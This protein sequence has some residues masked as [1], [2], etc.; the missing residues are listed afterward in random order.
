MPATRSW[1]RRKSSLGLVSVPPAK[2]GIYGVQTPEPNRLTFCPNVTPT[3]FKTEADAEDMY[4]DSAD[5]SSATLFPPSSTP[6][7]PPRRRRAPPGKRR[8][9]GYIPRPPNAFMLFRADFVKQKHVPNSIETNHSSLSKIIGSCWRSLPTEE[10][11]IWEKRAR[12]EKAEHKRKY[13]EYRFRPVHNKN[14]TKSADSP[15]ANKKTKTDS[16]PP[17]LAS[18][19]ALRTE[20]EGF[21]AQS[22]L[23]GLKGDALK[24]KVSWWDDAHGWDESAEGMAALEARAM[25][26]HVQSNSDAFPARSAVPIARYPARRP[27]SVPLPNDFLPFQGGYQQTQQYLSQYSDAPFSHATETSHGLSMDLAGYNGTH[28][29]QSSFHMLPPLNALRPPSPSPTNFNVGSISRQQ[30][31]VLGG[32]RASSAQAFVNYGRPEDSWAIPHTNWPDVHGQWVGANWQTGYGEGTGSS[33]STSASSL[34]LQTETDELPEVDTSLFQPG[35]AFGG[36]TFSIPSSQQPQPSPFDVQQQCN[37]FENYSM[38]QS[39]DFELVQQF[40]QEQQNQFHNPHNLSLPALDTHS[41]SPLDTSPLS[42]SS[43]Q[44]YSPA[45]SGSPPPSEKE[46][47]LVLHAPQPVHPASVEDV[48]LTY[49]EHDQSPAQSSTEDFQMQSSGSRSASASLLAPIDSAAAFDD[50]WKGLSSSGSFAAVMGFSIDSTVQQ[51]DE[52]A[53]QQPSP[54]L[55]S[56]SGANS[57]EP[58]A[59]PR[60][61]NDEFQQ[62]VQTQHE[63]LTMY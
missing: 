8:S 31:M 20:R 24:E 60:P 38:E 46:Q 14:K 13:P 2:P 29:A 16:L 58:G 43:V 28:V 30:R 15:S 62:P 1:A 34:P 53:Y 33:P 25:T 11:A 22:L 7:P 23:D 6:A 10:K 21:I 32:R 41:Y 39:N 36:S 63:Q 9:L 56:E 52:F 37:P 49:H 44:S 50:L 54:V 27:S 40:L 18:I 51:A 3:T 12:A 55:E 48:G 26:P 57:H 45:Y 35:F 47:E 5:D 19:E 61:G 17:P 4:D 42:S 59:F